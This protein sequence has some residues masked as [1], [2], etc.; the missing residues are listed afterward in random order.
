MPR[1]KKT[2]DED[3]FNSLAPPKFQRP[4]MTY[5]SLKSITVQQLQNIFSFEHVDIKIE[6]LHKMFDDGAPKNADGTV[7]YFEFGAWLLKG[8]E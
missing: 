5:A 4:K 6:D 3:F 8:S 7:N 1:K 2:T